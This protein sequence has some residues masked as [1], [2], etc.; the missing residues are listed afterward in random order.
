MLESRAETD[1]IEQIDGL[2]LRA[3]LPAQFHWHHHIFERGQRGDELEVLK[4]ESDQL[5]AQPGASIFIKIGEPDIVEQHFADGRLVETGAETKQ[6][7]L[8]AARG[9]D[10]GAGRGGWNRKA[11]LVQ[12]GQDFVAIGITFRQSPD[13]QNGFRLHASFIIPRGTFGKGSVQAVRHIS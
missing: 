1:P 5:V 6:G 13:I 11:D 2:I 8:A 12:D 7:R 3:G 10:D 9:T 4:Y